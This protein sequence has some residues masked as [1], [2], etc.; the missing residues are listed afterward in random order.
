MNPPCVR[1]LRIAY[2]GTHFAGCPA[3]PGQRTICSALEQALARV[4]APPTALETLSRTD[5]GVHARGNVAV[6]ELPRVFSPTEL[7]AILARHLP[8]DLRCIAVATA[9]D[10][11]HVLGKTYAYTLD[12]SAWGDPL[13]ARTAHR[14]PRPPELGRLARLSE[15]LAGTHDFTAF[16]RGGETRHDLRRTL[17][18][19]QWVSGEGTLTFEVEG[20][21]FTYRLV[22]SLVGGMIAVAIGAC[23]EQDWHDALDGH[24]T[25]AS[26][27]TA[28]ARGLCLRWLDV[29]ADWCEE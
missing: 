12:V 27:Q 9:P 15:R 17:S 4:Q 23:S 28:P 29:P 8:E 3:L 5:A 26:R 20:Q 21:G 11:V 7:L 19:A 2:D 25:H 1:L 13:R 18:R 6:V 10:R 24:P 16:R 22:R 14:V